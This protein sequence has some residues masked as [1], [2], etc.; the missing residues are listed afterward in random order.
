M[1]GPTDAD[2][3]RWMCTVSACPECLDNVEAPLAAGPCPGGY[4]CDYLCQ[5]CGHEWST[6]WHDPACRFE[7]SSNWRLDRG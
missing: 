5:D 6:A 7:G 2:W 3:L 4:E 1:T